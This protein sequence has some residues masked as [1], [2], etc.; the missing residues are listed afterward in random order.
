MQTSSILNWAVVVGLI[1]F[2][3]PSLQDTPPITAA[4]LLQVIG[5]LHINMVDLPQAIGYGD[6]EIFI[7]ILS[8][9]D[10]FS[11]LPFS[12]FYSFVHFRNL[13]CVS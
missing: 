12:L 8:Q 13:W 10:V 1:T 9:F 4:N 6:R 11:L 3:F 2:R 5:F 7:A